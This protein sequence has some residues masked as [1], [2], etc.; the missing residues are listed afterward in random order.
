MGTN[1]YKL[2]S[3]A[4]TLKGGTACSFPHSMGCLCLTQFT[5][6]LTPEISAVKL[7]S[8]CEREPNNSTLREH[9]NADIKLLFCYVRTCLLVI[10]THSSQCAYQSKTLCP[11]LGREIRQKINLNSTQLWLRIVAIFITRSDFPYLYSDI[12]K[13]LLCKKRE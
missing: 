4:R 10:T 6:P 3:P 1:L 9:Q 7:I 13:Y 8:Q 2:W 5:M 11:V 12:S